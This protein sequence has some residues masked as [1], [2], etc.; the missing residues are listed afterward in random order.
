MRT[1]GV[2]ISPSASGSAPGGRRRGGARRQPMASES[3]SDGS[4]GDMDVVVEEEEE[5]EEPGPRVY[6]FEPPVVHLGAGWPLDL[7]LQGKNDDTDAEEADDVDDYDSYAGPSSSTRPP[8]TSQTRQGA[9]T[10]VK[11]KGKGRRVPKL[12]WVPQSLQSRSNAAQL[13]SVSP[14]SDMW[15]VDEDGSSDQESSLRDGQQVAAAG[16]VSLALQI[17]SVSLLTLAGN[18]HVRRPRVAP[19]PLPAVTPSPQHVSADPNAKFEE[20]NSYA[21]VGTYPYHPAQVR[22]VIIKI[23]FYRL[24]IP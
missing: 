12:K 13:R 4:D 3:T 5:E 19:V 2:G 17:L 6:E 18:P 16:M 7:W 15:D 11:K 21:E 24:L 20:R 1:H 9:K 22:S 10:Q 23:V 8:A 14:A